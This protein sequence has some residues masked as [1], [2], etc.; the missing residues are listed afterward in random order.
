MLLN[1]WT[2]L[3]IP[4]KEK[5]QVFG[6]PLMVIGIDVDPNNLTYTL[7]AKVES[8]LLQQVE[9]FCSVPPGLHSACFSL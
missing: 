1:L 5:K 9:D 6:S 7:P 2:E 8:D 3:G 4:F